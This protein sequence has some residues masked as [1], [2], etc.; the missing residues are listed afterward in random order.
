[1]ILGMPTFREPCSSFHQGEE[2]P[3]TKLF[4]RVVPFILRCLKQRNIKGTTRGNSLTLTL[5]LIMRNYV[6]S[7]DT[8]EHAC[9]EFLSNIFV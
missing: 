4:P 1:S 2:Q 9:R 6:L 3:D 8:H 7:R 5:T